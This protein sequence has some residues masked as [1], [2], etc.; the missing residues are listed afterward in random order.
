MQIKQSYVNFEG[1]N[2][3]FWLCQMASKTRLCI[4]PCFLLWNEILPNVLF[5][6]IIWSLRTASLRC[7]VSVETAFSFCL[8]PL[9]P[10]F[11]PGIE[12][13]DEGAPRPNVGKTDEGRALKIELVA[14][15]LSGALELLLSSPLF[16]FSSCV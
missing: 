14:A 2:L 7:V 6:F 13:D 12:I 10:R 5:L 16:L 15:A 4:F 1:Q 9:F 8:F 11:S 3:S